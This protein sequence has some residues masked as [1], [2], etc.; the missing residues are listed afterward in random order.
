[1]AEYI[2][3]E[4]AMT[5]PELPK[6][7]R[8]YQTDNLDDAYEQGWN[9]A[10]ECVSIIPAADVSVVRHGRWV[11][12]LKKRKAICYHCGGAFRIAYN[13]CP[14]CGADMREV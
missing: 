6:N 12:D 3:K 10:L 14:N 13:Y 2:E 8:H 7:K 11:Y 1:M 9:D 4:A 5:L